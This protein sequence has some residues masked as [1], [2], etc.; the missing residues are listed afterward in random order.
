MEERRCRGELLFCCGLRVS[1]T[2]GGSLAVDAFLLP[3]SFL[4]TAEI[5]VEGLCSMRFVEE[6]WI[7]LYERW[8]RM[9]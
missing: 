5:G 8:L 3:R 1:F 2:I 9:I 4:V 7:V 6:S